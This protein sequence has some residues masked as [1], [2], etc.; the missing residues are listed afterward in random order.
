MIERFPDAERAELGRLGQS[1]FDSCRTAW[2]DPQSLSREWRFFFEGFE[3][4]ATGIEPADGTAN[5]DQLNFQFGEDGWMLVQVYQWKDR[6]YYVFV[7]PDQPEP[8][9]P[10]VV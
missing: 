6:W 2:P 9:G 5:E 4:A 8:N 3:L 1:R 10:K 7:R